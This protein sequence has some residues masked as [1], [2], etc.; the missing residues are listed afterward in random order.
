[1]QQSVGVLA[2]N[3]VDLLFCRFPW[4]S[5]IARDLGTAQDHLGNLRGC[6]SVPLEKRSLF[7]L[8][9]RNFSEY[10]DP[11]SPDPDANCNPTKKFVMSSLRSISPS[12]VA[13]S[14]TH[15]SSPSPCPSL[16]RHLS[17]LDHDDAHIPLRLHRDLGRLFSSSPFL[18]RPF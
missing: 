7:H 11:K 18:S 13:P 15:S 17:S 5:S 2:L 16:P 14:H 4:S 10:Q 9:R 3:D 6:C 8:F 12:P 1:M